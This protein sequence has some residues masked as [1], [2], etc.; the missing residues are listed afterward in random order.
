MLKLSD[1]THTWRLILLIAFSIQASGC[2]AQS[3]DSPAPVVP[4]H[5]RQTFGINMAP[6]NYYAEEWLFNDA[7]LTR[8]I[9]QVHFEGKWHVPEM[10]P[11]YSPDGWPLSLKPGVTVGVLVLREMH[12]R[13]GPYRLSWTGNGR[14][15]ATFAASAVSIPGRQDM[16]LN[17]GETFK[18]G[19]QII[20]EQTDPDDPIDQLKMIPVGL[21]DK[22]YAPEFFERH[23]S[24]VGGAQGVLRNVGWM[25][26]AHYPDEPVRWEDRTLPGQIQNKMAYEHQIAIWN[27]LK[28]NPWMCIPLL[29]TDDY[30][31]ELFKMLKRDLH[32]EA[33]VRVELSNEVWNS[34]FSQNKWSIQEAKRLGLKHMF[35]E[36]AYLIH[37]SKEI[38]AIWEE[39]FG[40]RQRL[41]RI[42]ATQISYEDRVKATAALAQGHADELAVGAYFGPLA[43][44]WVE[45]GEWVVDG[46]TVKRRLKPGTTID[47]VMDKMYEGIDTACQRMRNIK[48]IANQHGLRLV[49]YEGGQHLVA[50]GANVHVPEI[51]ELCIQ[52]NAHPQMRQVYQEY[53]SRI[54]Q[55]GLDM[56]CVFSSVARPSKW[57]S[58][59]TWP[60]MMNDQQTALQRSAKGDAVLE[61]AKLWRQ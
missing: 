58:W 57:G 18:G 25:N 38:W 23:R 48:Q 39:V 21:E 34:G 32:P 45:Q 28:T 53:L 42:A 20:I 59:G 19:V 50:T 17:V 2:D 1:A 37:R 54:R 9:P 11:P 26:I 60:Q 13:R 5:K 30:C 35:M 14:I 43:D 55:S 31:R 52:A 27:E 41:V 33:V 6:Q 16:I 46:K 7:M 44:Q 24:T 36:Q 15:R 47:D 29:A 40:D 4:E 22:T 8:S 12:A 61:A 56:I 49:A 10:A 3:S 51:T